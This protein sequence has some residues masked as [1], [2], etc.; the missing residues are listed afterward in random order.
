MLR[1]GPR[2]LTASEVA[3]AFE[4]LAAI[5]AVGVGD[6]TVDVPAGRLR[7]LARYG[8]SAKAQTL[9]RLSPQRRTATL[10]AALWQLEL[11]ATDDAL[12]LLD[13]VTD[14]LLSHATREHKDRRYAQLPDLD[15][16]ARA[17]AGRGAR[18]ARPAGRRHR[19][20]VERDRR[21]V[22][23]TELE[24]ATDTVH[25][26]ASQPDPQDG[27]D[28][29]F[30]ERAAAPLPEPQA[31]PAD[32]ARYRL[33]RGRPGR[34]GRS[35]TAMESLRALEGR[36]GRVSAATV[37]LKVVS[38]RWRRL[39]LA[40]PQLGE[41]EVDRRAYAFCV[42]EALQAALNR[43]DVFVSRSGR[44]TDPRAKLL[45]GPAWTAARPEICAGLSL[46]PAPQ[47]AL[48]QLGAQ[49]DSAYRQTAERLDDNLALEIAEIAGNDRPDLSKLETKYPSW[50]A[51]AWGLR[52]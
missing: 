3:E 26:L 51:T 1:A 45:Q 29:A 35:S 37:S 28:A 52:T 44:F 33:I 50:I 31:L 10:L 7:A 13:Q 42:L 47:R 5:R 25:R 39:V 34:T 18:A 11:D 2:K 36:P 17:P 8:L 6:L 19:G 49:L 43:R 9:R 30:R 20:A 22:P 15:R 23:R 16:A 14:L 12:I 32:P 46:D 4:R 38:G 40:N 24:L 41:N 48:E 27:Q 21:H